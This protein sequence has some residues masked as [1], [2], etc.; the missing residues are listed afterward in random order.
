MIP[1]YAVIGMLSALGFRAVRRALPN[2]P[3]AQDRIIGASLGVLAVA[4]VSY[5]SISNAAIYRLTQI[6][7]FSSPS[8]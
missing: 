7:T 3:V 1:A 4:D 8:E 6:F 2:D 5:F